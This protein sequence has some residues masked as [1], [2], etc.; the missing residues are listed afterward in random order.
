MKQSKILGVLALALSLML[1]ACGQGGASE[2]SA[3]AGS[4]KHTHK[5]GDW[6]VVQPATCEQ[7]GSEKAVCSICGND[8]FNNSSFDQNAFQEFYLLFGTFSC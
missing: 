6:Q 7:A 4:S 1:S 3:A 2:E 5:Y 8:L